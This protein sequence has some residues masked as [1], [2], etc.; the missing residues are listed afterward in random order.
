MCFCS[1]LR[2]MV[3]ADELDKEDFATEAVI[4]W[5]S[6]RDGTA[7]KCLDEDAPTKAED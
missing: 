1:L 5:T 3:G 6:V 2:A 4:G 7:A